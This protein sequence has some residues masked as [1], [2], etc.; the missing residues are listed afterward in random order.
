MSGTGFVSP[1]GLMKN[2][3]FG[4]TDKLDYSIALHLRGRGAFPHVISFAPRPNLG[5]SGPIRYGMDVANKITDAGH[6]LNRWTMMLNT[7]TQNGIA[8]FSNDD[9]F[10]MFKMLIDCPTWTP[11]SERY[12]L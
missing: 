4:D 10:L 12:A 3:Y 5:S 1:Y 2:R 8:A 6:V 11:D 9:D 7:H